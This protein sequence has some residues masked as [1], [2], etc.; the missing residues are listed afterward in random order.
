MKHSHCVAIDLFLQSSMA[1]GNPFVFAGS[2][3]QETRRRR[4]CERWKPADGRKWEKHGKIRKHSETWWNFRRLSTTRW[5]K[6]CQAIGF[7]VLLP[8]VWTRKPWRC[9]KIFNT[10][11][12]DVRYTW[13]T[14]VDVFCRFLYGGVFLYVVLFLSLGSSLTFGLLASWLLGFCGSCGSC[15][16]R[17]LGFW[18]V[19]AVGLLACWLL[20]FLWF[21]VC[22]LLLFFCGFLAIC[23]NYWA[24]K[25]NLQR[26]EG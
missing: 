6:W 20:K 1:T 3:G 14:L 23:C 26:I 18:A 13:Y 15:G 19:V 2:Q 17:F 5:D 4:K 12:A 24:D 8:R 22:W 25:G 7:E 10:W 16:F 21:L 9:A 11:S